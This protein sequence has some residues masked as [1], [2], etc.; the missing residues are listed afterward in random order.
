MGPGVAHAHAHE[1][2]RR[3]VQRRVLQ[4]V[5]VLNAA[6][7]I[8]EIVGGVAFHSLALVADAAHMVSDVAGLAIALAAQRL[9]ER[10]ATVRHSYGLQRAEVLAAQASGMLLVAVAIWVMI[11]AARRVG[12]APDVVG[13]GLLAVALAGLCVNVLSAVL[14]ARAGGES[15][16]M[17]GA[18]LHMALDALGSVG[19][20]VA[21]VAVIAWGA[22]WVDPAVSIAIGVLVLIAA[23]GLL[24]DTMVVLLEGAPRGVDSRVVAAALAESPDVVGVHHLHI[25]NLASDVSALSV[26]VQLG[27]EVTLHEAQVTGAELKAMLHDRFGIDHATV[28]LECHACDGPDDAL[29]APAATHHDH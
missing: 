14:L 19:A 20:A 24:R 6:F 13:G 1:H 23:W 21:G 16:N 25:W 28:E 17:R 29:H 22:T 3:G 27:G 8:V 7:L 4:R 10:P 2:D 26:H 12:S 5:L 11:E 15:L 9:L 18:F